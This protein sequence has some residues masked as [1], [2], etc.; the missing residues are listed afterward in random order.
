VI[1]RSADGVVDPIPTLPLA[2]IVNIDAP[3]EDATL[4]G[5][6]GDEVEDCTLKV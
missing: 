5:L 4:N 6:R 2:K 3:V 1:V